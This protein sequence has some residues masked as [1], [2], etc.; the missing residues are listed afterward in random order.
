MGIGVGSGRHHD[1]CGH[2]LPH[3]NSAARDA[4]PYDRIQTNKGH[5]MVVRGRADGRQASNDD[6]G[7]LGAMMAE[8]RLGIGTHGKQYEAGAR[9]TEPLTLLQSPCTM[10]CTKRT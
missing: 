6:A 7:W 9:A 1:Q 5:G 2:E 4:Q 10:Y 8:Q 3:F